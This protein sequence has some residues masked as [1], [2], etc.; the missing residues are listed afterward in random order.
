MQIR[1]SVGFT[2][3][4]VRP[5]SC[6]LSQ[7]SSCHFNYAQISAA[8][9]L[10]HHHIASTRHAQKDS[11]K[12]ETSGQI[13]Q[14][15]PSVGFTA[16]HV[17]PQSCWLSQM[18]SCHF[19]YAQISAARNL[20]H[21]HI[22]STRCAQK[23]STKKETSG[24]IMQIRPSVGFTAPHVRPQSCWLSQMSSCHFNYA[25]ISAAR[26]L[27]HHHIASTRHAQKDSTKKETSG[28]IMQIRPSVGFTAPHVRPQSC[29]L[30]QMSSCHFNYAQISAA[31][32]LLHHHIA[33]TRCAQKDSTKKETSGQIMQI[34]PSV[35]FT[36]PHVRP[37]SCWLSQM[38]SCHFNYAQIS[39]ARNLLHHHIASTRLAPKR[40]NQERN[41]WADHA[42]QTICW[43]Y[44]SACAPSVMLAKSN[45][46]LSFQLCT[47]FCG[48]KPITP[49]HCKH[50][51]CTKGLNQERNKWADHANQ[52]ICWIYCSACAPSVMLAKSN[53][54]LSFQLCTDF[55]GKKPITPP[56]CK[57]PPCTKG[58]NQERNKWADH[59]NQTICWI[60]CSACAPSVML[61]K[62]N[63]ILSFQLCTDFCGKKPI[64]PPHCKHPPCT[65]GLNQERNKWADH[66]NQTICWIYCSACAPS[67]MLAKSNVILS[68]QLC[69]DF[70]G[71]KPITPPHC[72][73]P[74]C[75]KG[76][77]QERNKWADHANQ[78]ICWI[79]CSAC[80]PSV[81]LAKSNVIQCRYLR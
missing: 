2:A 24:Q 19:N 77:N 26:N 27:L 52:T 64:T 38:S 54:I 81:M 5:Q 23:D 48:K 34:R 46:I 47:D 12:K 33:S 17:R 7:M 76:L 50:P 6:W 44:C 79:Y 35:G 32:N 67:V 71:K 69:T 70:C 22:A 56:H 43:I 68:F 51:P 18:S 62:S 29:W 4:H 65:K 63:V 10:L 60:Y 14:I 40:L 11:T 58:L 15:R 36:A 42:N 13:M 21:H 49:P 31:R 61:A 55:C 45:V 30:S 1:P 16:P 74:P 37:Q 28:Q 25:Q 3:P 57:H 78:T 9:N 73:H 53:V 8:R 72:K 41:K 75:T 80:A 59:A 39:A 66:A 20:L